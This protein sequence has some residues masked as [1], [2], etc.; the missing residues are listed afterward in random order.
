MIFKTKFFEKILCSDGFITNHFLKSGRINSY[1]KI[2]FNVTLVLQLAP[3]HSFVLVFRTFY[4]N[5]EYK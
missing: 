5:K 3:T 4:V 2:S 1:I